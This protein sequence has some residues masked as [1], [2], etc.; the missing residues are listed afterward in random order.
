LETETLI[1]EREA[2]TLIKN[3][4]SF[5]FKPKHITLLQDT[6]IHKL[7]HQHLHIRFWEL[8]TGEEVT[9][10]VSEDVLKA[11]PFPVVIHNFIENY[12]SKH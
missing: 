5:G 11:Y 2:V 12:W 10:A 6:I 7:S 9:G 3:A 8:A 4:E 1:T